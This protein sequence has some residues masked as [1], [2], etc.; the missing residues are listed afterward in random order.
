MAKI[1]FKGN[2]VNTSGD[3]IKPGAFAP[4]F[5]LTGSDMS[6]ISI[7][8]YAGKKIILNIFPSI[9]TSVCATSVRKFNQEAGNLNNTV[10]LC[11]SAD[12]P[13]AQ[14]RFCG[15]EGLTNV[16]TLST[17][18]DNQF[19]DLYG[20]RMTDGPL[21]GLLSR[22]VVIIGTDGKVIYSQQVPDIAQEPDYKSA[23]NAVRN[24]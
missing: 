2:T 24:S 10:V 1:T 20:V 19:G 4:E 14:S 16:V 17:F 11:I 9:D 5:T 23:L 3:L 21:A 6:E 22:V 8:K 15:A 7:K 12:L 18:R 13:F